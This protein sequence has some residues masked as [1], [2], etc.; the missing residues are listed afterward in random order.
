MRLAACCAAHLGLTVA[1]GGSALGEAR[2]ALA[3]VPVAAAAAH[4]VQRRAGTRG[5][6]ADR[7]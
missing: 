2:F 3:T 1:V 7:C 4:A 5:A 6:D